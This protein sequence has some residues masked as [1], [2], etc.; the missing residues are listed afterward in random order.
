M[1]TIIQLWTRNRRR[2]LAWFQ[3]DVFHR[4][5]AGPTAGRIRSARGSGAAFPCRAAVAD[6][7]KGID[8]AEPEGLVATH[9]YE[10]IGQYI[11]G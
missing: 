2:V 3:D 6:R 9:K 10:D 5:T 11:V 4:L 7:R 1:E 8:A